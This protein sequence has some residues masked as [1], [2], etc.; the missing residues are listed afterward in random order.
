MSAA[1]FAIDRLRYAILLWKQ[2]VR[3]SNPLVLV[4]SSMPAMSCAC[5]GCNANTAA[6]MSKAIIGCM[7][8]SCLRFAPRR[9]CGSE[10]PEPHEAVEHHEGPQS[11][12]FE[13]LKAAGQTW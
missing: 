12:W 13:V 9:R 6:A 10:R 4:Q 8:P 2:P 7:S 5:A 11:G 1:F 3:L